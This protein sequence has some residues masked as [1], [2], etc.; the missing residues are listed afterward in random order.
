MS[1]ATFPGVNSDGSA[2]I[3]RT[4][5]TFDPNATLNVAANHLPV[6]SDCTI[7]P[8][9]SIVSG[10]SFIVNGAYTYVGLAGGAAAV[11]PGDRLVYNGGT[12]TAAAS[13]TSVDE[14]VRYPANA[15]IIGQIDPAFL[16]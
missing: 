5:G 4:R 16:V 2:S 3:W 13:W 1:T 12:V 15:K 8:S 6:Q 11:Q 10:D 14:S 9:M 7:G